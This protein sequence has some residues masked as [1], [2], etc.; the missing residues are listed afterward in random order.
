MQAPLI[1]EQCKKDDVIRIADP[2]ATAGDGEALD[3]WG[4]LTL[5]DGHYL[6][7]KCNA[8]ELRFGKSFIDWD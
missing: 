5:T 1:C 8:M 4:D 6:C 2:R 3:H 7:P